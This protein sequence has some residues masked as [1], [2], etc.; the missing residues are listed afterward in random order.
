[1]VTAERGVNAHAGRSRIR[2]STRR[3]VITRD[4]RA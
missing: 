4:G 2:T 1:L 3:L